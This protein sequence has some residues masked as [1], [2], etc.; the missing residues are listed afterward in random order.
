MTIEHKD[1]VSLERHEAK[2]F[3]DAANETAYVKNASGLSEFKPFSEIGGTG[4]TGP[5]GSLANIDV[6]NIDDPST[7]MALIGIAGGEFV[8]ARQQINL[9]NDEQTS[10]TYDANN[11]EAV[12]APY[13]VATLEG[14]N[15]RW[16]ATG[17]KYTNGNLT[18]ELAARLISEDEQHVVAL[19]DSTGILDGGEISVN[20]DTTKFDIAAGEGHIVDAFTDPTNPVDC[21]IEWNAFTAID[22]DF[23]LTANASYIGL[24]KGSVLPSGHYDATIIQQ[25]TPF[26]N[27]QERDVISIGIANHVGATISVTTQVSRFIANPFNQLVDLAKSIGTLNLSGNVFSA[28]GSDMTLSKSAGVS[29]LIGVNYATSKKSPNTKSN[30]PL[31]APLF[32]GT[33]RDGVGGWVTESP[34]A[35]ISNFWDDG[36]GV[37]QT[38]A[39]NRFAIHRI[40]YSQGGFVVTQYGQAVYTSISNA[41]SAIATEAF[42]KNPTVDSLP[43]RSWLIVKGGTTDLSN[44]ADVKFINAGKFG[45]AGGGAGGS[46]SATMQSTYNNSVEPEI[47]INAIN[48]AVTTQDADTPTGLNLVEVKN[49]NAVKTLM[50]TDINRTEFQQQVYS[51]ENSLVDA[52]NIATNC[53]LGNVHSVTLA[54]N[55]TLDNPTNLKAG[56]TYIWIITQDG[57]G[58]RTL[59]YGTAFKFPGGTAPT[60]TTDANA[61]DI[62]TG[63]SDGT[64]IYCNLTG[65]FS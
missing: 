16:I 25:S 65:D 15:T 57:T 47:K 42:D 19:I 20:A 64:N 11:T 22:P 44:A 52:A 18:N 62:L 58:S 13:I 1:I 4:P 5:A 9:T 33:Y 24:I 6:A 61:V 3:E 26:T 59:S 34:T 35:S 49:A 10:Y 41:E 31:A 46:S 2:G 28:F 48:G 27:E 8:I 50:A 55:R 23:L 40:Y 30:T 14:G 51:L 12:N 21:Q 39:G 56:A 7:E 37:L 63:I 60:L 29:Y 43:V 38:V 17:G 53:N 36:S 45:D 54:G 32:F